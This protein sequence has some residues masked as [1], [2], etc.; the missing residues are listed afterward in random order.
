MASEHTAL[1]TRGDVLLRVAV[2][3][4]G[5]ARMQALAYWKAVTADRSEFL[6]GLRR[7]H[8]EPPLARLI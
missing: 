5:E 3:F 1:H 4:G 6:D 2:H 7:I 8:S